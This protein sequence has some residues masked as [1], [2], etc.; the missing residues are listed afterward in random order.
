MSRMVKFIAAAAVVVTFG[1]GPV[2]VAHGEPGGGGSG[3][4]DSSKPGDNKSK[5]K[6]KDRD[7]DR[8]GR[9]RDSDGPKPT[10][11]SSAA[12]T[13]EPSPPS[14]QPQHPSTS[15]TAIPDF[16]DPNSGSDDNP[17]AAEPSGESPQP[18]SPATPT[19]SSPTTSTVRIGSVGGTPDLPGS[20][21]L[22][23]TLPVG[24]QASRSPYHL[25]TDRVFSIAPGT[26]GPFPGG[27]PR[28]APRTI[29]PNANTGATAGWS[30][31]LIVPNALGKSGGALPGPGGGRSETIR[32]PTAPGELRVPG[33]GGRLPEIGVERMVRLRVVKATPI[34]TRPVTTMLGDTET[35]V[36]YQFQYEM[37]T[38]YVGTLGGNPTIT[39]GPSD[40][41]PITTDGVI[42]LAQA[43]VPLPTLK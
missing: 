23:E 26:A 38:Q 8:P 18:P 9:D 30:G 40:W 36:R 43:G 29:D 33:K 28:T 14:T 6:D 27:D 20:A 10:S 25:G 34:G 7:R 12:P 17:A 37:Q 3:S 42:A 15:A 13:A 21:V 31:N 22:E 16:P 41:A 5:D 35:L 4:H 1:A 19:A 24:G 11:P 32:I 2:A 39:P